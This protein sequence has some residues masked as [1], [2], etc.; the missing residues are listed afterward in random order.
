[1]KM[2]MLFPALRVVR[3]YLYTKQQTM[4]S[5]E[6]ARIAS[7]IV[8]KTGSPASGE[9][10]VLSRQPVKADPVVSQLLLKYFFSPFQNEE[11][12]QFFHPSGLDIHQMYQHVRAIFS[13]PE[14][15]YEKSV[16]IAQHLF[17]SSNHPKIKSGELYLA[18]MH[19]CIIDGESADAIGI[20]KSESKETYLKIHPKAGGFELNSE[21]GINLK[22][23]DKGCIVFNVEKEDGY[24]LVQVDNLSKQAEARYWVDDFLGISQ[25]QN[26]Y[27]Q[28]HNTLELCKD[29]VDGQLS[30]D[31][32]VSMLDKSEILARSA[33][34]FKEKD[35]FNLND[36]TQEVL[37]QPEVVE[38]FENYKSDFE[39]KNDLQ[40][41]EEF[42]ISGSAVK[43][44]ARFF[45]SVIK[46]DK[47]FHVYVHGNRERIERGYDSARGL[48]F[49]RLYFEQES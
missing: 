2:C 41:E 30:K 32:E 19:N 46:L 17:H 37:Q 7:L 40:L 15:L 11:Y 26:N 18:Y 16:Y 42:D 25:R 4:I 48:H 12:Y 9:E 31:F 20:F 47:N 5:A 35:T 21:E 13:D 14:C 22:K 10:V 38:A 23:L 34:Y 44:Q 1:M 45:K 33:R 8:H 27:Y 28:T 49:Y 36:F 39:V 24:L 43:K 3:L 29:F 6:M